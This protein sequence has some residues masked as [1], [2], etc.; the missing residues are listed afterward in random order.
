MDLFDMTFEMKHQSKQLDKQAI[1]VEQQMKKEEKKCL[2]LMDQGLPDAAKISAE[3][4]IR[5]KNEGLNC[6]RMAA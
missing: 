4:V 6:R 3:N 5:L 2:D 1:K